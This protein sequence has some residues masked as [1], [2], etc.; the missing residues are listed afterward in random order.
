MKDFSMKFALPEG[1]L[2]ATRLTKSGRLAEAA[3]ALR[4]LGGGGLPNGFKM[5]TIQAFQAPA[6]QPF[7]SP[8]PQAFKAPPAS[9]P[10]DAGRFLSASFTNRA[11]SRSYK[12]Y[13]PKSYTG[14]AAPLIVMLH[15]CS[16]SPDD[17]AAGTRMNE[18]AEE[19]VASW[20]IPCRRV[21]PMPR[22]AGTGSARATSAGTRG[23]GP[24]CRDHARGDA[25]IRSRP[26][27]RI[28]RRSL[29][30]RSRGGDYGRGLPRSVCR[31]R[32]A[33]GAGLRSRTRHDVGFR[34]HAERRR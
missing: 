19:K 8:A 1:L 26:A 24:D 11:G 29:G 18:V 22:N 25:R 33:F 4:G 32:R 15:G 30:W 34:R 14:Q 12:L 9:Q 6:P 23:A 31:H 13:V 2:E 20:P 16:Q 3:E 10:G 28:R 7:S 17:F 21:R 5:P 27:P